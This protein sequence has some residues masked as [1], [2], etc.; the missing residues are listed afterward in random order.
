M[1]P[2]PRQPLVVALGVLAP[3]LLIF[4][5]WLGGHPDRL[6]GPLRDALVGDTDAQT[7]DRALDEVHSEY[8]RPVPRDE[9]VDAALR[10]V[11]RSLHDRFSSYFTARQYRD[12]QE[13]TDAEFSGVGLTAREDP[14]GLLVDEVF[15]DSPAKRAGIRSGDVI[16]G[17]DGH[18]LHGKP[19]EASRALIKGRPGTRVRLTILSRGRRRTETVQR[20][21]V[22]VP[23]VASHLGRL[24][25]GRRYAD[26]ALAQ[27]SSGAHGEL[28]AAID[29][30]L[31]EGA[32]GLVLD[33]R[34]NGGGL[35]E[36]A[37]LVASIFIPEGPIVSTRGRAQRPRTL[38]AAGG[39]IAKDIPVVALV[40]GDTA[41][42]A[43]IVAGAL[44]DRH[45]AKVVG[46]HTFGKGVFQEV[47]TLPNGGALDLTVG[48]Y[49]TPSGRNLGGAGV[50]RG[51]GVKPDV[52]ARDDPH[53]PRYDEA[54]AAAKRVL[55]GGR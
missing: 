51:S 19:G 9:L 35:V 54:L 53:T 12:F 47:T 37:R 5:I 29:K 7:V 39:A 26:V 41:S 16:V 38:M 3:V 32:K 15:D 30:R 2:R 44:Q 31:Q 46:S 27:F 36:E 23:V 43:E 17:V 55:A 20:A 34:G 49:F 22:S 10:G 6:P 42:A 45:R 18:S 33:L 21:T 1:H 24:A 48:Q 40:D 28:R 50:K 11:V 52:V 8:Y 13:S 4:G 25:D 14:R